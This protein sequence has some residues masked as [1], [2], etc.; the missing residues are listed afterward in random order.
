MNDSCWSAASRR[1][2]LTRVLRSLLSLCLGIVVSACAGS[3]VPTSRPSEPAPS[4]GAPSPAGA[5]PTPAD[6]ATIKPGESWLVYQRWTNE[7]GARIRLIRPDG[8]GDH[9]LLSE[10]TGEQTHP[11]WSPDGERVAYVEDNDIWVVNVDG[12]GAER[13]FDCAASCIVGDAPAWSP[14]GQSIAFVTADAVGDIA[15]GMRILAIDMV[16]RALRTLFETVGPEYAW[17]VRWSPDGRSIVLDLTRYPDTKVTTSTVIG[18]EVAIVDLDA[19]KPVA[20]PLT[21]PSMFATY[22]DWNRVTGQIVFTTF[23]LGVRDAGGFEDPAPPSDLY[24]IDPDG[25]GLLA[26]THNET[27]STLIRNGTASGALSTQPT[28]TPDGSGI[29]FVQVDGPSWPGWG[30]ALIAPDGTG[31]TPAA[32]SMYLLGTHP[33]LRPTP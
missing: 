11:D 15:P 12:S 17:W 25:T 27:S 29:V 6:D 14:D 24:T 8:T 3:S 22:P 5:S 9:A 18:S 7:T 20:R 2:V 26:L 13:V 4:V 21:D 32:G 28:W 30:M 16:S 23:D 33:R 1:R 10:A 31:L 19:A